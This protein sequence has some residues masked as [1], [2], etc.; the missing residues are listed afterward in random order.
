VIV[1]P[2]PSDPAALADVTGAHSEMIHLAYRRNVPAHH[3]RESDPHYHLFNEVRARLKRAGKLVCWR[4][5]S[6]EDIQ[7]HHN[8]C[9]FC[10]QKGVDVAKFAHLYP[11]LMPE[12]SEECFLAAIE[13]EGGLL[14]LCQHCHTGRGTGIHYVPYPDW[15]PMRFWKD[16][17][18]STTEAVA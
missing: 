13:S 7:V 1:I 10:M 17:F 11:E 14:P 18:T 15:L 8:L 12:C 6:R 4:C 2:H 9:E 16:G 5:A 3:V